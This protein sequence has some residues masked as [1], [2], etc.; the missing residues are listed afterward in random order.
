VFN[1][2][3]ANKQ[4]SN[5]G[6]KTLAFVCNKLNKIFVVKNKISLDL[7]LI[8]FIPQRQTDLT[9]GDK[10]FNRGMNSYNWANNIF[11]DE[12]KKEDDYG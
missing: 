11:R 9:S 1:I 2:S 10:H 8:L 12:K 5:N 7:V 6:V 3:F 4:T